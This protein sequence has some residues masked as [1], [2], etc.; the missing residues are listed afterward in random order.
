MKAS[1]LPLLHFCISAW[2]AALLPITVMADT[3]KDAVDLV[4]RMSVP[5]KVASGK[6]V[7]FKFALSNRG[8]KAVNVLTWNTPLEGFY[9]KHLQVTGPQGELEYNGAMVKRAA[10][11][12]EEYVSIKPGATVSKTLNLA[13]A[14]EMNMTGKYELTFNGRLLD[15]T[16]G[17]IPRGFTEQSALDIPCPVVRFEIGRAGK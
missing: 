3:G 9:G 15:A 17:K 8:K 11:T 4:C 2:A 13:T 7:P 14:Y 16:T 12:R 10:P 1:P 6:S 5:A